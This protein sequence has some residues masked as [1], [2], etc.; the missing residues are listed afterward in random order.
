MCVINQEE[1]EGRS[2]CIS[3]PRRRS[4]RSGKTL[5]KLLVFSVVLGFSLVVLVI[6]GVWA[7][8]GF[9]TVATYAGIRAAAALTADGPPAPGGVPPD[10][11]G[12]PPAPDGM[13][14]VPVV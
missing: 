5:I 14:P 13:S 2:E 1:P 12:V 11:G 4:R 8:G 3:T 9:V 7:A 10:S 6:A